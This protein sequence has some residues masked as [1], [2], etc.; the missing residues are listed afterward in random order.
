M[1]QPHALEHHAD[2][3]RDF[4]YWKA[5]NRAAE[6]AAFRRTCEALTGALPSWAARR[7]AGRKARTE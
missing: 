6:C 4:Q 2:L 7:P 5:N 3:K 1:A